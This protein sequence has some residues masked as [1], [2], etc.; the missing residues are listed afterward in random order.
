MNL[1]RYSF[2]ND[3]YQ[4]MGP[5]QTRQQHWRWN[6]FDSSFVTLVNYHSGF[7]LVFSSAKPSADSVCRFREEPGDDLCF[8]EG[9]GIIYH[10]IDDFYT[11]RKDLPSS[12]SSD[13]LNHLTTTDE[14]LA[15]I[16]NLKLKEI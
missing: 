8:A 4:N 7:I 2:L 1:W 10:H 13:L 5:A 11:W 6:L 12:H 14:F 15:A 16:Y 3:L 9:H